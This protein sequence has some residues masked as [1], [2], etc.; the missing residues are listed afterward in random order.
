MKIALLIVVLMSSFNNLVGQ[1][2]PQFDDMWVIQRDISDEF[3]EEKLDNDKW[4]KP[5]YNWG[6]DG[7]YYYF[8]M[9]NVKVENGEL[10]LI[11]DTA[12]SNRPFYYSGGIQSKS[13]DYSFGYYEL[14][15][16]LPAYEKNGKQCGKGFWPCFWTYY[17]ERDGNCIVEHDEIDI[18]EPCGH[19]FEDASTNVVGWHDIDSTDCPNTMKLDEY[20]FTHDSPL[21]LDYHL[22]GV[23]W[24]PDS[25]NNN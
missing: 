19:Q 12:N 14:K 2:S 7:H 21:S 23:E 11:A 22:F 18:L 20:K 25:N 24:L 17:Q 9:E 10:L 8:R 3:N 6:G 1:I 4:M 15:A 5:P 13:N 16:I